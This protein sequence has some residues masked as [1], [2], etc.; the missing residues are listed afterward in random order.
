MKLVITKKP[1]VNYQSW[2]DEIQ[3]TRMNRDKGQVKI[4]KMVLLLCMFDRDFYD[5]YK[6][7]KPDEISLN[8]YSYITDNKKIQQISFDNTR[9]CRNN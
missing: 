5:W 1:S 4:Y 8:F 7:V 6:P 9:K 3:T 2:F